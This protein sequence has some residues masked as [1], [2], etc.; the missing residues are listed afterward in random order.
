MELFW[1]TV[2][3]NGFHRH[4]CVFEFCHHQIC[5]LLQLAFHVTAKYRKARTKT[6]KFAKVNISKM[7]K[8]VTNGNKRNT[9]IYFNTLSFPFLSNSGADLMCSSD[10]VTALGPCSITSLNH[11][12]RVLIQ[13]LPFS[14]QLKHH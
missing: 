12:K 8:Y 3:K 6:W 13:E 10:Q 1:V 4:S 9:S 5:T 2:R 7:Q 11:T 14:K